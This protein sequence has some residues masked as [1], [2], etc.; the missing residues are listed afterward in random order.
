MRLRWI[1]VLCLA[2]GVATAAPYHEVVTDKNWR[3]QVQPTRRP[4]VVGVESPT[5]PAHAKVHLSL[6]E[7]ILLSL[8]NN[9][10]IQSAQLSRV[11]DK[12]SLWVAHNAY[13][14]QFTLGGQSNWVQGNQSVYTA[15]SGVTL[16]TRYGTQ[17]GVNYNNTLSGGGGP[18]ITTFS[19][20][21]PLLQGFGRKVNEIPW[22]NALDSENMSRLN[23]QGTMMAQVVEIT[24]NYYQLMQDYQNLDIQQRTLQNT[25]HTLQ[26]STLRY[27]VGQLAKSDLLQQKTTYETTR[28]TWLRQRSGLLADYQ[29]FLAALGL[30]ADAQ[31]T[32]DHDVDL[33]H[34]HIPSVQQAIK[35]ALQ[36]NV[37]YQ[38]QL[39]AIRAL[40]RAVTS[41][42]DAARW[43][44][45]L[46]GN[47]AVAGTSSLWQFWNNTGGNTPTA[48]N[49]QNNPSLIASLSIP[50]NN[51]PQKQAVMNASLQLEQAQWQLRELRDNLVRQITNQVQQ[52]QN[53]K[54]TLEAAERQV[55]YQRATME[56]AKIRYR[57]GRATAFELNQ[58]QDQLLS[59][60][61]ALVATRVALLM[62][63]TT[64]DQWLGR[65]LSVWQIELQY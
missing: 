65:S 29:A 49:L 58:L 57:Y 35:L 4:G 56:A 12:F 8:R 22:L 33:S 64:L 2:Q 41:A 46:T 26:E 10:H 54:L 11:M 61:I 47:Y 43:Q 51:M 42:K 28:L 23:Y 63:A 32:I 13:L 16:N 20:T 39:I 59:Q 15:N 21:Q 31:I 9:P 19:I 62:Q 37:G 48:F 24:N 17:F 53:Q 36:G 18:A 6:R 38:Q 1:W 5:L 3:Q 14:P 25:Q 45:N 55:A 52:L 34:L 30:P 7:A 40:Q 60:E 50:I 27:K 44:L